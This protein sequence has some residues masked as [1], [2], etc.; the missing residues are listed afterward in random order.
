MFKFKFNI[1][2]YLTIFFLSIIGCEGG[3][4]DSL[5]NT[6]LSPSGTTV[7]PDAPQGDGK[8]LTVDCKSSYESLCN[9]NS[10]PNNTTATP[11]IPQGAGQPLIVLLHG[12]G[13]DASCFDILKGNL[14]KA[15]PTAKIIALKSVEGDKTFL[16]SIKEQADLSF[17]ELKTLLTCP[18]HGVNSPILLI[19]HSQGGNRACAIAAKN[20][21]LN[22]KGIVTLAT[23]WEG[24]PNA[25]RDP[26]S[27]SML[28]N[29]S[30]IF[31]FF[32]PDDNTNLF[33]ILTDLKNQPG[34]KD[35]I[36]GSQFLTEISQNLNT[37][38]VPIRAIGGTSST[39]I[40]ILDLGID[41][42]QLL[43][44]LISGR[45]APD[46]RHD[47]LVSLAS[48]LASNISKGIQNFERVIIQ[49]AAHN[50]FLLRLCP[51]ETQVI[52]EHPQTFEA[53]T[54][55]INEVLPEAT[56]KHVDNKR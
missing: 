1:S 55:F 23:P 16:H 26:E 35:L 44:D 8:P 32:S 46:K 10:S 4:C 49:N 34:S 20:K 43:G 47:T 30:Q 56:Q 24:G 19:G 12:L 9:T 36:P 50:A 11:D 33:K 31:S 52:L 45:N 51:P 29:L 5:R 41:P 13:S 3:S 7:S 21:G 6:S 28:E 22:I 39:N 37:L 14:E 40:K 15:Y 48:Q 53:V 25:M 42:D 54:K 27:K 18:E 38:N 2:I 17:E